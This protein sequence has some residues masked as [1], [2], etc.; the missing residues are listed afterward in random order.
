MAGMASSSTGGNS[1]DSSRIFREIASLTAV[2]E[3]PVA[4]AT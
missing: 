4:P 1:D 3:A 2:I